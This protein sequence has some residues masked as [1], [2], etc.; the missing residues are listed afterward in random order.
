MCHLK[1][2][3]GYIIEL[4]Q[5]TFG[6]NQQPPE[7]DPDLL[8]GSQPTLAHITLRCK[9]PAVSIP[10][11]RDLLG[12]RLMSRQQINE[13]GFTLYFLAYTDEVTPSEDINSVQDREWLWQ[14]PYTMIELQHIRRSEDTVFE[15]RTDED[16]P[17]GFRG[18]T[19]F[20]AD[21]PE[22]FR[23]TK[24]FNFTVESPESGYLAPGQPLIL[25]DPDGTQIRIVDQE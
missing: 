1:D 25:R 6:R 20:A 7:P 5:H 14:R 4:L 17:Y 15:Y 22:L 2:P 9:N 16:G 23:R 3:D 24:G 18:V 13:R 12:M 10:F 19:I 21:R 11:Y 8:L